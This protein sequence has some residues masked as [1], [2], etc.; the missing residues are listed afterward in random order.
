MEF[1]SFPFTEKDPEDK[2]VQGRALLSCREMIPSRPL[3]GVWPNCS[4]IFLAEAWGYGHELPAPTTSQLKTTA[5]HLLFGKILLHFW[6]TWA[7]WSTAGYN[8]EV[9]RRRCAAL[10]QADLA[11]ECKTHDISTP[12]LPRWPERGVS[13]HAVRLFHKG[14][15]ESPDT[16]STS[17][18]VFVLSS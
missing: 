10:R 1:L 3:L 5:Q 15:Y 4:P 12:G 7:T 11:S 9:C 8:A 2:R 17:V 16:G 6:L 13:W 18:L 14:N